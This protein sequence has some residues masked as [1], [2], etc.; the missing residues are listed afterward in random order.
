M[1]TSLRIGLIGT[2]TAGSIVLFLVVAHPGRLLASLGAL[3]ASAVA[4]AIVNLG[5]FAA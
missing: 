3:P 5:V 2:T 4:S 1:R